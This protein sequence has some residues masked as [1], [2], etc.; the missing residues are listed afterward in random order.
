VDP[1]AAAAGPPVDASRLA[2]TDQPVISQQLL[3]TIRCPDCRA[4][5][6]P[7]GEAALACTAC[8]RRFARHAGY[9]DLRPAAAYDE[10][11]K[12]LDEQ[13]HADARHLHVSPPL[14]GA[15]VRQWMLRRFLRPAPG[16]LV[17][18]LG[19]GSGQSLVWNQ[20]SGATLVG[21]DVSP[22]FAAE[23]LANGQLVLGDLRRLPFADASFTKG[24]ALDVFEHLSPQG[25]A[26]VLD[27]IARVVGPGGQVFVY[28]HVRKNAWI[29]GGVRAVNALSH[30]L[31]R[32]GLIDLRQ[33]HLRKSDHLNP[34]ADIPELEAVAG[35]AG[36]RIARIR[37]YTPILGALVQN[38]FMRLGERAMGRRAG[39]RAT[40]AAT[41]PGDAHVEEAR[42]ARAEA[43]AKLRRR[44]P[45]YVALRAVTALMT[46][47][48]WLF[49]RIR[50][51]PF[52][53]LLERRGSVRD[54]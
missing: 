24:Y 54:A 13:L 2:G 9:L 33:E 21:V 36:F 14:L 12:Y 16:D 10:Q 7:D 11:T 53:V 20:A 22:F 6:V 32:L 49:G 3:A 23:P 31:A 28:S 27:E 8:G 52:F 41:L 38:V 50:S 39:R 48:V 17:I 4:T 25:L 46:L 18:D 45:F 5:L 30:G 51:G 34:L 35:R 44:G 15:G 1:A 42:L 47:D 19:C 43:K 26:A 40:G 29:A 37:Y